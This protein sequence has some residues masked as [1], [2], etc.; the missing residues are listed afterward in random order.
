MSSNGAE[1]LMSME[2]PIA[3]L[4]A[5]QAITE[6]IYRYCRAV[7][8]CD[9]E[10]LSGCFHADATHNHGV[11]DGRSAD[12]CRFALQLL[13]MIGSTQHH[14]GNVLIA[15]DGA[16]AHSEAYWVAHHR[17]LANGPGEE[18][19]IFASRGIDEDL[20]IGGRYIDRFECRGS[21]WRIAHRI[22]V[23]DWQRYETAAERDFKALPASMRGTRGRQDRSYWQG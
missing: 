7:D 11:F 6:V 14:V 21:V 19:G 10:L 18:A 12:F 2:A 8:R 17:I 3:D 16:R 23:H 4:L 1:G 5:K 15:V 22:G 13:A 9:A 20:F